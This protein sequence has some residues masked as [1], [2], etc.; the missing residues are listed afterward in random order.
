[1]R[2]PRPPLS[3]RQAMPAQEPRISPPSIATLELSALSLN[4]AREGLIT[5]A[6]LTYICGH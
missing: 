4:R 2:G 6:A 5:R 3:L 1:M